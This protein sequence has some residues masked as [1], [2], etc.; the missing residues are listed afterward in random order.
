M[1]L[2]SLVDRHVWPEHQ[3]GPSK[4]ICDDFGPSNVIVNNAKDLQIV[5][6]VD[7]EWSY[8]GPAQLLGTAPWWL[9]Q[10]RPHNWSDS[11]D[12][13]ARFLE[14]LDMF[15]RVLGEEE[16][17]GPPAGPGESLSAMVRRSEERGTM[18]FHM[19]LQSFFLDPDS[20]PCAQLRAETP[21]WDE[22]AAAIP[23]RD[24]QSFVAK[25]MAQRK[26]HDR[27]EEWAKATRDDMREGKMTV[28]EFIEKI[29][30]RFRTPNSPLP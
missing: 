18:W 2:K 17:K 27:M 11:A 28:P 1:V 30:A 19:V 6:V 15:K 5:A 13:R 26:E 14:H 22:L 23:K 7:L 24:I 8:V 29:E 9:L 12:R 21:D 20:F 3:T 10:E 16:E 25:K 4:L